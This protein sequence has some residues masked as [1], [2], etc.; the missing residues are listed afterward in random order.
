MYTQSVLMAGIGGGEGEGWRGEGRDVE[1][2][3][4][5]EGERGKGGEE[6]VLLAGGGGGG[7]GWDILMMQHDM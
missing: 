3:G 2:G 6:G 7:G 5:G 4:E 1:R